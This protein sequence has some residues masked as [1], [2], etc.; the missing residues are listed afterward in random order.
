M[1]SSLGFT[2]VITRGASQDLR[3]LITESGISGVARQLNFALSTSLLFDGTRDVFVLLHGPTAETEASK[4]HTVLRVSQ[5][6]N[7]LFFFSRV[8]VYATLFL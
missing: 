3:S 4:L 7:V 6:R 2:V 8:T 5:S 1:R